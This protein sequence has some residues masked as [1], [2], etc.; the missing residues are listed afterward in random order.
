MRLNITLRD[1][2]AGQAIG[3]I[4]TIE[5]YDSFE[6]LAALAYEMADSMILKS[7]SGLKENSDPK[8]KGPSSVYSPEFESF[9]KEYPRRIGKGKAYKNWQTALKNTDPLVIIEG[10]KRYAAECLAKRTEE[11]YIKHPEGWL[12]ARRWEDD[13]SIPQ[14][15]PI[16]GGI[17]L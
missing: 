10:A 6:I 15:K 1:Y 16:I 13:A 4:V 9:W 2:F 5:K 8:K 11:G 14:Q 17:T 7:N 12:T 3:A